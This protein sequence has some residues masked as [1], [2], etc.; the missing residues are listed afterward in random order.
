M[1]PVFDEMQQHRRNRIGTQTLSLM[2]YCLLVEILLANLGIRWAT[3]P[4]DIMVILVGCCGV[5]CL[6]C[7]WADAM[8]APQQKWGKGFALTML[9]SL[10]VAMGVAWGIVSGRIPMDPPQTTAA[11]SML[12]M[13][14]SW[15]FLLSMGCLAAFKRWK[16]RR[17]EQ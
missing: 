6:R 16:N 1:K 8:I 2:I 10:F 17:E 4:T 9:L 5:F 3:Y 13:A 7:I 11:D 15:G 14:V 12:L